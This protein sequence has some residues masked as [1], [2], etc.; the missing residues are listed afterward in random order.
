MNETR[1]RQQLL[2]GFE[3]FASRMRLR[4]IYYGQNKE[5]H[6][7]YVKSTW[8]PAIQP[9]VALESCLEEVKVH[10]AE[11]NFTKPEEISRLKNVRQLRKP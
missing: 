5:P 1:I 7:F 3:D 8:I 9:S 2:R 10:L 6:P 4:Y 11:A